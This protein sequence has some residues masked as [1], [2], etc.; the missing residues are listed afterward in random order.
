[1]ANDALKLKIDT[2]EVLRKFK[3]L[4]QPGKSRLLKAAGMAGALPIFNEAQQ[5]A[6]VKTGTLKRSIHIEV[7]LLSDDRIRIT[8]GTNLV[9]AA[10]VEFGFMVADSRGR[11]YNLPPKPYLRPAFDGKKELA[12]REITLALVDGIYQLV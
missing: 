10:R 8:I 7:I 5:L 6:A 2:D 4:E 3:A 9:Y 1:M 11:K 12:K